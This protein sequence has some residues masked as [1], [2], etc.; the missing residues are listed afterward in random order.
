[1]N[2]QF[3]YFSLRK[4]IYAC[5]TSFIYDSN[6]LSAYFSSINKTA[7]VANFYKT[8]PFFVAGMS[9]HTILPPCH[10]VSITACKQH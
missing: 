7:A 3:L 2:K 6:D 8:I 5:H 1:M 10:L 4:D 9:K